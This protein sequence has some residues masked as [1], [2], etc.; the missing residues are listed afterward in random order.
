MFLKIFYYFVLK[1]VVFRTTANL[2]YSSDEGIHVTFYNI[3]NHKIII[4]TK[5]YSSAINLQRI[6]NFE[7]TIFRYREYLLIKPAGTIVPAGPNFT[8]LNLR[9][10][11]SHHLIKI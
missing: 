2:R 5:R 7:Q 1:S 6:K 3:N 11:R 10:H 4:Q 8:K 9:M